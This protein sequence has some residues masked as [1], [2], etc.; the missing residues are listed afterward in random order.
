MIMPADTERTPW[1]QF[2]KT[3]GKD[4]LDQ[5]MYYGV[6]KIFLLE[7]GGI[8]LSDCKLFCVKHLGRFGKTCMRKVQ[9][10][11]KRKNL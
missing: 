10:R 5:C 4:L 9:M 8:A 1:R 6:S 2:L 3:N 11:A 7:F